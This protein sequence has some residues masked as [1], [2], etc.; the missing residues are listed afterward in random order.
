ML[1]VEADAAVMPRWIAAV[2]SALAVD[3]MTAAG[4]SFTTAD[5]DA[6]HA[7]VAPAAGVIISATDVLAVVEV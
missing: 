6:V 2:A 7:V 4:V 1:A 5:I 3:V